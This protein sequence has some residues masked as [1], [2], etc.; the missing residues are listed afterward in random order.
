[1]VEEVSE[2][3][4]NMMSAQIDAISG[5]NLVLPFSLGVPTFLNEGG[6]LFLDHAAEVLLGEL[7]HSFNLHGALIIITIKRYCHN[8][9]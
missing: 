8:N 4:G 7:L 9:I 1:M 6:E 2:G 5:F 3:E